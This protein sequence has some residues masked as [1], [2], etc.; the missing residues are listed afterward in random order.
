MRAVGST[1]ALI[2]AIGAL[3]WYGSGGLRRPASDAAACATPVSEEWVRGGTECLH[4]RTYRSPHAGPH[5]DL[6][7][8]LHGDAPFGPPGYQYAAART[9]SQHTDNVVAVGLLRPGYTDDGG[10]RSSGL[11][12]HAL[13]DNYTPAVVDAITGAIDALRATYQPAHI[14]LVGHSGGAAIAADVLGRHPASVDGAVLVSCPCDVPA[15]RH[16]MLE[17]QHTPFWLLP[18]SSLSPAT[19]VSTVDP[20]AT[21]TVVV[22]SADNVVP[23][24]IGRAYV[25]LL[26]VHGVAA[27]LVE[28]PGASHDILLDPRVISVTASTLASLRL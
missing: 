25:G 14:L 15:F 9:I 5:A 7:I 21:V 6:V 17:A 23:P 2:V 4:I 10:H 12:G 20:R 19:L 28:L 26:R 3:W 27:N 18:V 13:A 16:H 22:G 24:E 1:L 8:V 11:R